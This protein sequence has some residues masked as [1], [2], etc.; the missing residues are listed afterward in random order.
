MDY[1]YHDALMRAVAAYREMEYCLGK[2]KMASVDSLEQEAKKL[3]FIADRSSFMQ[4]NQSL[5]TP[6]PVVQFIPYSEDEVSC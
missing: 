3:D 6:P 4:E 5:F 1:D 2:I